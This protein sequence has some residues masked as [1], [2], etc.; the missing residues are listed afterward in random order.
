LVLHQQ[1]VALEVD[2]GGSFVQNTSTNGLV[3]TL[4]TF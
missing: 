2:S 3:A 4:G 1:L